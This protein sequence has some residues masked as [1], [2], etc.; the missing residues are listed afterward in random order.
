MDGPLY[1]GDGLPP[2]VDARVRAELRDGERLIWVGQP[3]PGRFARRA[4]PFV[5]FGVPWTAFALFWMGMAAFM[6]FGAGGNNGGFG[7]MACFP[8]FGL[9]FV[10]IGF[11]MLSSPYWMRLQAKRTCYALTDRRAIIWS[12]SLFGSVEVRSYGPEALGKISRTEYPDG[13]GDLVLEEVVTVGRDSDGHGTTYR[14]RH[15]FLAIRNVRR[16][17]ELLR[18]ALLPDG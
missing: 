2:D 3:V 13:T 5:L 11:G 6:M 9:P 14:K 8:L 4:L 10:L 7:F 12:A 1:D 15:G 18:A 16:V 17:E